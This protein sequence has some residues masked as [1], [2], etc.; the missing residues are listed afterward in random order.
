MIALSLAAAGCGSNDPSADSVACTG[1][2]KIKASGATDGEFCHFKIDGANCYYNPGTHETG[3]FCLE[4][5]ANPDVKSVK[6]T[7]HVK[8]TASGATD[9]E[10]CHFKL[11]GQTC[12]Y[13]PGTHETGAFCPPVRGG[14]SEDQ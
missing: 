10:F 13:N 3:A 5:E 11:G 2:L 12:Y 1:S 6:C 7:G 14:S 9:G 8:I 4:G